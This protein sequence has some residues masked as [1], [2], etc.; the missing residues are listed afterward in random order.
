MLAAGGPLHSLDD[1]ST[2]PSSTPAPKRRKRATTGPRSDHVTW[3]RSPK[4]NGHVISDI[5]DLLRAKEPSS[6]PSSHEEVHAPPPSIGKLSWLLP[7]A[8]S[9]RQYGSAAAAAAG[10]AHG[11]ASSEDGLLSLLNH[12][13]DSPPAGPG[14]TDDDDEIE[15]ACLRAEHEVQRRL[16]L[17]AARDVAL[18]DDRVGWIPQ[19]RACPPGSCGSA[20]R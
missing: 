7:E 11:T 20:T 16:F 2:P 13:E 19:R 3:R 4:Q 18:D 1:N 12:L 17:A 10:A 15:L 5:E 14:A 8:A 9:S 6:T